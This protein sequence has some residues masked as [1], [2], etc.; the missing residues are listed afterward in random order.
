MVG[1]CMMLVMWNKVYDL[2]DMQGG[3]I[4]SVV[5]IVLEESMEGR[6]AYTFMDV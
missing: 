6:F 3:C 4:I 5:Y 1:V 2:I